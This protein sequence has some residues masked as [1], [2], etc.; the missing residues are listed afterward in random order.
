MRACSMQS[1]LA[2]YFVERL[3]IIIYSQH[4]LFATGA[5]TPN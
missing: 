5:T 3:P 4:L 1:L 2:L